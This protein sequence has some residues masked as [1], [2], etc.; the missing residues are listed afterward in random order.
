MVSA[1]KY[2]INV[3]SLL[4]YRRLSVRAHPRHTVPQEN[5]QLVDLVRLYPKVESLQLEW[6]RTLEGQAGSLRHSDV[7]CDLPELKRL[8]LDVA[9]DLDGPYARFAA[10]TANSFPC[11]TGELG[12]I[13]CHL[14][15]AN[16]KDVT[17]MIDQWVNSWEFDLHFQELQ[18]ALMKMRFPQM[19]TFTAELTI[20][21]ET[22]LE[23][24]SIW[25]SVAI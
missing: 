19:E 2:F 8:V 18:L 5:N 20:E 9:T 25:V 3:P 10:D 14:P 23:P 12:M 22:P 17:V 16:I 24:V 4:H 6:D 15:F 11:A 21:V 1:A 13:L 7:I